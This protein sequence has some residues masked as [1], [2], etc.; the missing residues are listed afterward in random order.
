MAADY[1]QAERLLQMTTPLGADV[2]VL[3]A[4]DVDEAIGSLYTIEAEAIS[5]RADIQAGELIGR[6]I[7]CTVALP[8]RPPR[9]FHGIVQSFHRAGDYG[10][11]MSLYRVT[12]VPRLWQLSRTSDCRIFQNQS[13]QRIVQ[14]V[15]EEGH[16]S[17]VRFGNLPAAARDYCV[18]WNETDLDFVQRLLDE[19]GAGFFFRHEQGEHT[20]H[21]TGANAD[22]PTI[23]CAPVTNRPGAENGGP[24]TVWGWSA[25]TAQR[26][27]RSEALDYDQLRPAALQKTS[28]STMLATSA[29]EAEMFSWPGNQTPQPDVDPARLSMERGEAH[30][31]AVRA[32]GGEPAVFAGGR[33]QVAPALGAA[34][35][36][37]LVTAVQHRARDDS[38]IAG[39]S[40][41]HYGN[42]LSLMQADRT[43][44]GAAPRP[45]P[46]MPG[47]QSAIVTGPQGGEIHCDEYGRV[48]VHFHWDR[49]GPR[50]EGSSCWVRVAQPWAGSWGGTWFLPRVGDEVLVGFMD[51][52]PDKPVVI[53]SLYNDAARQQHAMPGNMTRSWISSRSSKGGGAENANILRLEDKAGAEE[54]YLQAEK[55][56]NLLVRD[57]RGATVQKGNDTLLVEKGNISV[58]AQQGRIEIEAMQSI[59]LKVGSSKIT[60]DSS[61]VTIEGTLVTAKATGT[62]RIEAPLIQEDASGSMILKGGII[63]IN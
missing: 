26:P 43:W 59:T 33:L 3:R 4:L 10:R 2:L 1:V 21:V 56:L 62:A 44:R 37:W 46:V 20:L 48:K 40:S 30:A 29:A 9:H 16:V 34:P 32:E 8:G 17:P 11:G 19:V 50:T 60:I 5:H 41:S 7:T 27:G 38:H 54:F 14:T 36:S 47:L 63:H 57:N 42:S 6:G 51:G 25:A 45:R 39:G 18:Q 52:D 28:A 23:A 55:D 22:F 31:E 53:G 12:A 49:A 24:D 61:G 58:T 35:S 15:L 13:V